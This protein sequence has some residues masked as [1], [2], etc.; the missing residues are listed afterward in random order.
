MQICLNAYTV[1]DLIECDLSLREQTKLGCS[2][3]CLACHRGRLSLLRDDFA[4]SYSSNRSLQFK[5]GLRTKSELTDTDICHKNMSLFS[6]YTSVS[7][8]IETNGYMN[9]SKENRVCR[10]F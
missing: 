6:M 5:I 8:E 3:P 2:L 10:V 7:L 1:I 9:I 4:L